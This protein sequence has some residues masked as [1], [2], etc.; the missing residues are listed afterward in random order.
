[1]SFR[2]FLS[3]FLSVCF[4]KFNFFL[5]YLFY[6]TP[7]PR[8]FHFII[9]AVSQCDLPPVRPH[10]GEALGPDSN[11]EWAIYPLD[12]Y[13]SFS[14]KIKLMRVRGNKGRQCGKLCRGVELRQ[15]AKHPCCHI[16]YNC[17][18]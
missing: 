10:C 9:C 12:H 17:K 1:M 2:G 4:W 18:Q 6:S 14:K 13:S 16:L 11:P 3:L 7:R 5:N 15:S 8:G